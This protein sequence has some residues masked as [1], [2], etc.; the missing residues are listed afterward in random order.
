MKPNELSQLH[1]QDANNQSGLQQQASGSGAANNMSA[2]V[3]VQSSG[4]EPSAE[5]Q[6]Q[7]PRDQQNGTK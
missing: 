6:F 4:N 1:S 5:Q 2:A 3:Q 7:P